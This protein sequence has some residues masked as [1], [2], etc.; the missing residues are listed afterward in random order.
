M[1][2]YFDFVRHLTLHI[3]AIL[4]V[5]SVVDVWLYSRLT[6]TPRNFVE[7]LEKSKNS[8]LR[9]VSYGMTCDWCVGHWVAL[10]FYIACRYTTDFP[11]T[12]FEMIA[13]TPITARFASI[14][15]E[16]APGLFAFVDYKG[17]DNN[18]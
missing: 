3:A 18:E 7:N 1:T 11:L 16:N 17:E 5:W 12:W 14:I 6:Q 8:W 9:F 15:R 10:I 2:T 4:F 13:A